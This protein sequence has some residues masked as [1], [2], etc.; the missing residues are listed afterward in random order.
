MCKKREVIIIL[1]TNE[2]VRDAYMDALGAMSS[3]VKI[4]NS[5][6][7]E[8]QINLLSVSLNTITA[9][10]EFIPV[11]YMKIN[12]LELLKT[13]LSASAGLYSHNLGRIQLRDIPNNH[14]NKT[15]LLGINLAHEYGHHV[16]G[17]ILRSNDPELINKMESL[18]TKMGDSF[19]NKDHD[20][21]KNIIDKNNKVYDSTMEYLSSPTE[22]FARAFSGMVLKDVESCYERGTCFG[23]NYTTKELEG[24]ESELKDLCMEYSNKVLSKDKIKNKD[25]FKHLDNETKALICKNE[26][27]LFSKHV[28]EAK[29]D[30][31]SKKNIDAETTLRKKTYNGIFKNISKEARNE[32]RYNPKEDVV[33][34]VSNEE[35]T[36]NFLSMTPNEVY[37]KNNALEN[38][39]RLIMQQL[40]TYSI[41]NTGKNREDLI[42]R[43]NNINIETRVLDST[44]IKESKD[45][46]YYSK[47]KDKENS[48]NSFLNS[49]DVT[50]DGKFYSPL[51]RT[52]LVQYIKGKIVDKYE[53]KLTDVQSEINNFENYYNECKTKSKHPVEN[54]HCADVSENNA[55]HKYSTTLVAKTYENG[56]KDDFITDIQAHQ[57]ARYDMNDYRKVVDINH[58]K[59][60]NCRDIIDNT[61]QNINQGITT[62]KHMNKSMHKKVKDKM[63][64]K[65]PFYKEKDSAKQKHMDIEDKKE[66]SADEMIDKL[67]KEASEKKNEPVASNLCAEANKQIDTLLAKCYTEENDKCNDTKIRNYEYSNEMEF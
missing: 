39:K 51:E 42:R 2:R 65:V 13:D 54:Y 19:C 12:N 27:I 62:Y 1:L 25:L 20:K 66:L 5:M 7:M 26:T 44:G 32:F 38:E 63:L 57:R 30:V 33:L 29:K 3:T 6:S 10:N 67:L 64:A 21:L 43:L 41:G 40:N 61:W 36:N 4:D 55:V 53:C 23:Y 48:I 45:Y 18:I 46:V 31:S 17:S 35:M 60:I 15:S 22:M 9:V 11:N 14:K 59:M 28:T 47:L 37:D 8:E 34:A 24:F 49:F 58:P 52:K 16:Y 50:T 56:Y